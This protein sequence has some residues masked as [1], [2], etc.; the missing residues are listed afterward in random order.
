M[1]LAVIA[2]G[3]ILGS[4]ARML[5]ALV[6]PWSGG[7]PWAT[8]LVNIV[9]S[10]AM[11]V[12]AAVIVDTRP[13]LR[14]FLLTG[15]LGGFTTFS[16]F[17]YESATLLDAGEVVTALVYVAATLAGGLLAYSLGQRLARPRSAT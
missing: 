14:P 2:A 7:W 6:L 5:L 8:L 1:R 9:G 16:A 17:A 4:A 15:V 13:L 12:L 11:G 3:G 10:L